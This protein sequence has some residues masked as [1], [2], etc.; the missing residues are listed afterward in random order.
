MQSSSISLMRLCC[1]MDSFD[2]YLSFFISFITGVNIIQ[3]KTSSINQLL[4]LGWNHKL[5]IGNPNIFS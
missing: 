3:H 2:H 4:L 5:L 1:S